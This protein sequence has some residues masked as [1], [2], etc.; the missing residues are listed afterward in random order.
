MMARDTPGAP[1]LGVQPL[2]PLSWLQRTGEVRP[3]RPVRLWLGADHKWPINLLPADTFSISGG[4][5]TDFE[6]ISQR[7]ELESGQIGGRG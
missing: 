6:A 4:G 2:A 5:I 7:N 3:A 1:H